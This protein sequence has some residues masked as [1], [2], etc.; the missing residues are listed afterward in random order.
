MSAAKRKRTQEPITIELSTRERD[1]IVNHGYPFE[2]I[3]RQIRLA[4]NRRRASISDDP[5]WWEQVIGNLCISIR[6]PERAEI[7]DQLDDLAER[8]ELEAAFRSVP[9]VFSQA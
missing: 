8:I 5:Y 6:D 7:A 3:E 4:G 2:E 9:R 1:L